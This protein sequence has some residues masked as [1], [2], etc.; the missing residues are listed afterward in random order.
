MF[1]VR[2]PSATPPDGE[3]RPGG[4]RRREPHPTLL[5]SF[6]PSL[7]PSLSARRWHRHGEAKRQQTEARPAAGRAATCDHGG[8]GLRGECEGE[9]ERERESWP[10]VC[11]L[12]RRRRCLHQ[13]CRER[14]R[15]RDRG[16]RRRRRTQLPERGNGRGRVA[17]FSSDRSLARSLPRSS[18]PRFSSHIRLS[19]SPSR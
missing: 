14:R 3:R 17:A 2:T 4:P 1:A 19:L 6:P 9:R 5:P 10:P 8:G 16:H 18:A 13:S 11:S 12:R 7:L 15:P